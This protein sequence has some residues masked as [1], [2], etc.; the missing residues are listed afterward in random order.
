[1]GEGLRKSRVRDGSPFARPIRHP[2]ALPANSG[3]YF[4]RDQ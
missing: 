1:M 3:P 2:P 4:P